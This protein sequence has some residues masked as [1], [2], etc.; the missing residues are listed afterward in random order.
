MKIDFKKASE[1]IQTHGPILGKGMLRLLYG[2]F[3]AGLFAVGICGLIRVASLGGWAAVF[4]CLGSVG[5]II[6]ALMAT[7]IM[8]GTCKKGAKK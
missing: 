6:A 8:G 2:A 1:W 3:T 5:C 7:Y 4:S